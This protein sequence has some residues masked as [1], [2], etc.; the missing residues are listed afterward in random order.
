MCKTRD[1]FNEQLVSEKVTLETLKNKI[2]VILKRAKTR[3][4]EPEMSTIVLS[5][6]NE[7]DINR[8]VHDRKDLKESEIRRKQQERRKKYKLV[9]LQLV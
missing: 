6:T 7:C 8:K 5:L 1:E 4:T 3:E 2:R 9:Y